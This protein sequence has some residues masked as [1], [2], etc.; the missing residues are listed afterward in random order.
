MIRQK[1]LCKEEYESLAEFRYGLRAFLHFSEEAAQEVG[2]TPQQHQALLAIKGFPGRDR[3]T[4]GELAERLR[5]RHHSTVGLI[6]RLVAE[7]LVMRRPSPEDGRQVLIALTSHGEKILEQ[8]SAVHRDQLK[9]I[10][11]E[12]ADL[13]RRLS[14][15]DVG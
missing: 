6:N 3:I 10:G 14:D 11:P 7:K 13:I 15:C 9:I 5:L 8:L 2:L 1:T 4:I 12:L